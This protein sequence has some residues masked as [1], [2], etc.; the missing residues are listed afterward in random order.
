M[1]N[2]I[3]RVSNR[4][5][6]RPAS[7]GSRR[8]IADSKSVPR[9]SI[10]AGQRVSKTGTGISNS[11]PQSNRAELNN[12]GNAASGNRRQRPADQGRHI[13]N[14]RCG[15]YDAGGDS[16]RSGDQIKQM[17]Q[18]GQVVGGNLRAGGDSKNDER[19]PGANP[20]KL[21]RKSE[22]SSQRCNVHYEQRQ[23]NAKSG[24]S[25][26][27]D[28]QKYVQYVFQIYASFSLGFSLRASQIICSMRF[29]CGFSSAIFCTRSNS[30]WIVA[31][32]SSISSRQRLPERWAKLLR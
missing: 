30:A 2:Q 8:E 22:R 15:D 14:D 12:G 10:E 19:W 17:V 5:V 29:S 16:G 21:S 20:G 26:Q 7:R 31:P 6:K 32:N 3:S 13:G 4:I 1:A 9:F 24:G 28:S 23:E 11:T 18:P 25:G 27:S